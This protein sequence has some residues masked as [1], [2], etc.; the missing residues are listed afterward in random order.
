MKQEY[1]YK[2]GDWFSHI[3]PNLTPMV[4]KF[5]GKPI[6][7]LE[8]GCFEGRSTVWFI[9]NLLKHHPQAC[10]E[11]VDPWQGFSDLAGLTDWEDIKARWEKNVANAAHESLVDPICIGQNRMTSREFFK[12]EKSEFDL[13]YVDGSHDKADAAFDLF[14]SWD[15]LKSKGVL[16]A[17]DYDW[18][19]PHG[20]DQ[21]NLPCQAIDFFKDCVERNGELEYFSTAHQAY[22]VKK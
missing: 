11:C 5:I 2:Y 12:N 22:F 9:E 1:D 20:W 21:Q 8:I 17:D 10:M 3:L 14:N 13:I 18:V 16:V 15:C 4:Q 19:G 6:D 7:I